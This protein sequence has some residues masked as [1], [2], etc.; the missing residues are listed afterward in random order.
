M[1]IVLAG[2]FKWNRNDI[3]II[4]R[5]GKDNVFI[6]LSEE[7]KLSIEHEEVDIII[8]NWF[9]KYHSLKEFKKL[10]YIQ[11]LSAG[12]NGIT[13]EEAERYGIVIHNA[14]NVYSIPI[15]EFVVGNILQFY[16]NGYYFFENKK[17]HMWEKC[18]NLQELYLKNV[19]IVGTGSIGHEIAIRMNAFTPSVYGCNRTVKED[20]L[21]KKIFPLESLAEIV[22]EMDIVILS[23]AMTNETDHLINSKILSKMKH[24]SLI[25]NVSR[26]GIIDE[27]ALIDSLIK[28]DIGGAILDVFEE[29]PLGESSRFWNMDNVI[30]TPHNAFVSESNNNR[31]REV[32]FSNLKA[33]ENSNA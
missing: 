16:K 2:N 25:V 33:W 27:E 5:N 6:H 26:G 21:F 31:L 18:R 32:V 23:V 7:E 3:S 9:F 8:C 1:N 22:A 30:I 15:S 14:K 10:K 19:L 4:S 29:E 28:H 12:Y 24:N 17:K 13:L 11:L 20:V